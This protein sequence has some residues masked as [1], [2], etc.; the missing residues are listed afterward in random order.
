ML[1]DLA[2]GVAGAVARIPKP[3]IVAVP[4]VKCTVRVQP[5]L[6]YEV[7]A[8]DGPIAVPVIHK[9]GMNAFVTAWRV[10]RPF[11]ALRWFRTFRTRNKWV[12]VAVHHFASPA[13]LNAIFH[14]I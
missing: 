14:L 7:C 9:Q 4:T 8:L 3:L 2:L 13:P 1:L 6:A 11:D 5:Y 10:V 12:T